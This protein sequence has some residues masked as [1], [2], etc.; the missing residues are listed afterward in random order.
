MEDWSLGRFFMPIMSPGHAS[1]SCLHSLL[2]LLHTCFSANLPVN[3]GCDRVNMEQ[4]LWSRHRAIVFG[5]IIASKCGTEL[6]QNCGPVQG[7]NSSVVDLTE[8]EEEACSSSRI[9]VAVNAQGYVCGIHKPG[10]AAIQP[11]KLMVSH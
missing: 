3:G 8:E 11:G 5:R 4:N 6:K 9:H 1:N 10:A 7:G 2:P